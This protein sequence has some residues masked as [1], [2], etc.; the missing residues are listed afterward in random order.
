MSDPII[1]FRNVTKRYDENEVLTDVSIDIFK[2][3]FVTLIGKSGC[4]KTTFLKMINALLLPDEG[5]V[6]VF[7][8]D[9]AGVDH[10]ALRRKIGYVIQT[11]GL[12]P[13]MTV[14]KNIEYIPSLFKEGKEKAR[15]PRELMEM[16]S[17]EPDLLNRFPS[18]LSGGQKQ[19]VGIARALSIMPEILLMDEPFGA[20][21]EITRK[22]LQKSISEIHRDLGIT[23]LF[24]THAIDEALLL[25]SKVAIFEN[26]NI[27][28][29]D[30]PEAILKDPKDDFV[31]ELTSDYAHIMAEE[32]AAAEAAE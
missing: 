18:E 14:K 30:T 27:V 29:F 6:C 7:G 15:D 10:I 19:R 23:I 3:E 11:V 17:L 5:Q 22:Q 26:R 32:E 2:N 25:G 12:F 28:Q 1:T 24:V 9:I 8:E 31:R 4:G 16:V 13:H 20:V 21:D